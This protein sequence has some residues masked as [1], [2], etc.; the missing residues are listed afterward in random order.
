MIPV[1]V[2]AFVYRHALG[3]GNPIR[4]PIKLIPGVSPLRQALARSGLWPEIAPHLDYPISLINYEDAAKN[5]PHLAGTKSPI[6]PTEGSRDA[7][8]QKLVGL[9]EPVR[10]AAHVHKEGEAILISL[11]LPNL[12]TLIVTV[13]AKAEYNI[14]AAS[15]GKTDREMEPVDVTDKVKPY[16]KH[17]RLSTVF[18]RVRDLITKDFLGQGQPVA[19]GPESKDPSGFSAHPP[20]QNQDRKNEDEAKDVK[21]VAT[22]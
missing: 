12:Y 15:I 21:G 22:C 14:I 1:T 5:A 3:G 11:P 19:R 4:C 2:Q 20:S 13:E 17:T 16:G 8:S 7:I 6:G 18:Y 9:P 10:D